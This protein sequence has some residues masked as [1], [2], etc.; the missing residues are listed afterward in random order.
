MKDPYGTHQEPPD[1]ILALKQRIKELEQSEVERREI[2]KALKESEER[3]RQLVEGVSKGVFVAQDGMLKFV[4]PMGV[5]ILGHSQHDLTTLPFTHFIHPDDRNMV[6]ERHM[7]RV[8]GEK[9]ATRYDFRILTSGGNIRWVELD[10][11]TIQWE[12]RPAVLVFISDITDRKQAEDEI[13][14]ERE[15]LKTLSDNAPFGMV[16]LN[17]AGCFTY[18]NPK[19]T[20]LLGYDLSDIPDGRT[21]FK[22]AYPDTEYRRGAVSA[23][24]KDF[25]DAGPGAQKQ[26][27]FTVTCK[28]GTQAIMRFTPSVLASGDY[29]MT[30]EDITELRRLESHLR[31]AQKMESIGTLT[32]GVAHDFNNILSAL[33]GYASL[34]QVKMD[35]DSPLRPYV[36]Q[37][38]SASRKAA[39][40]TRSLLAFSRQ[41]P[42]T[43]APLDMNT[44]IES[45]KKL[46][47]RLLTEDIELRT[48]L[49]KEDTVVMADRSQIDQ[50]LFNLVTNARDS[51]PKG[52]TLIVKT[53]IADMDSRFTRAHGFGKPGR[54]VVIT[55]LDTGEGM[56]EATQ[57]KIFDPFFT[58]K[59]TGKGT[60]LGLAI[61]YSIVKQ[62]EGYITVY[63]ELNRGTAFRIYLPAVKA[64]ADH[65]ENAIFPVTTGNETILIAEDN[66]EVRRF[67][68]EALSEYGYRIIEAID[69]EDA[70]N[71]FNLHGGIDLIIVDSVMPKKNGREVYEEIHRINPRIKVL[72]TS[73]YTKDIV[74]NK[75]IE[76][77]EFDFIAKPLLLDELLRKI[78]E[79]LDRHPRNPSLSG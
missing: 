2:E 58:T 68:R 34:M 71:K 8:T 7:R 1:E 21:W 36:D 78:R 11:V 61:V 32:G 26:K 19:F 30:C 43:L 77:K 39:D 49:A 44:T 40:L 5:E 16:L 41:Q 70:I 57:G 50:I 47:K 67:M 46:L 63:S 56:D 17:K 25:S 27:V 45:T 59:E 65:E 53:G 18:I 10:S 69:G 75:G 23:W 38:L 73:G 48:S 79:V 13:L 15:K 4:N 6:M 31:Q 35:K 37:V 66:E 22:K 54:Y 60:G 72:F 14:L 28:D 3:Y 24:L 74:L 29:L 76:D 55:I 62:H 33:M 51:M 52:G 42:V 64:R 12:H 20:D 9:F